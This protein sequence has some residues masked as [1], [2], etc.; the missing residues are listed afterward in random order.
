MEIFTTLFG[1]LLPFLNYL[2]PTKSPFLLIA[3]IVIFC[4]V[5]P[6]AEMIR[7]SKGW[8]YHMPIYYLIFLTIV[9]SFKYEP[10]EANINYENDK[11]EQEEIDRIE[12][13]HQFKFSRSFCVGIGLLAMYALF[14]E[15][16]T[17]NEFWFIIFYLSLILHLIVFGLYLIFRTIRE[18]NVKKYSIFQIGFLSGLFMLGSILCYKKGVWHDDSLLYNCQGTYEVV[19]EDAAN[20]SRYKSQ[21]GGVL[22][23]KKQIKE[24]LKKCIDSPKFQNQQGYILEVD[25]VTYKKAIDWKVISAFILLISWAVYM[26]FWIIRLKNIVSFNVT[27]KD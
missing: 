2:R 23:R 26:I 24:E 1:P 10:P 9:L 5:A 4:L 14:R 16:Y 22:R 6:S 20:Q 25:P 7:G 17:G 13:E 18:E 27:V 11:L 8:L 15:K 12:I 19:V 21:Y 3:I